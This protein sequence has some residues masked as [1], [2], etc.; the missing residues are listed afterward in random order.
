M[1]TGALINYSDT[2]EGKEVDALCP[3]ADFVIV[4]IGNGANNKKIN[5]ILAHLLETKTETRLIFS[6][7]WRKN[8]LDLAKIHGFVQKWGI[9]DIYIRIFE[10]T[11]LDPEKFCLNLKNLVKEGC[12]FSLFGAILVPRVSASLLEQVYLGLISMY[13]MSVVGF[14]PLMS[15]KNIGKPDVE[16]LHSEKKYTPGIFIDDCDQLQ[17][18]IMLKDASRTYDEVFLFPSVALS[19]KKPTKVFS[20]S[21]K[22]KTY[23][24]WRCIIPT[25]LRLSPSMG[26]QILGRIQIGDEVDIDVIQEASG[27]IYG[28]TSD[29]FW[30]VIKGTN[31]EYIVQTS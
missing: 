11:D 31:R 12:H 16:S 26:A 23:P 27:I 30:A 20:V 5:A 29:G 2:P 14:S 13:G 10:G 4:D 22:V 21:E 28:R 7:T 6:P 18:D 9:K 17:L 1:K 8:E 25:S 19:E 24:R 15:W 3:W